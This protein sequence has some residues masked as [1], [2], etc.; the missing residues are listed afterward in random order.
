MINT[1]IFLIFVVTAIRKENYPAVDLGIL[2]CVGAQVLYSSNL[3]DVGWFWVKFTPS[4]FTV[5]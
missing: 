5:A 3:K 1:H 2:K 4:S